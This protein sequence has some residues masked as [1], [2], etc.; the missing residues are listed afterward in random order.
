MR[1][2]DIKA[3]QEILGHTTQRMTSR[4]T[5]LC[6]VHKAQQMQKMNGLTSGTNVEPPDHLGIKKGFNQIG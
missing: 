6:Q 1:T 5:H 2:G 4:Y 3:L